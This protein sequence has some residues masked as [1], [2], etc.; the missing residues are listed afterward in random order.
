MD[1]P[2]SDGWTS[3]NGTDA[4]TGPVD[5]PWP[6]LALSAI[7]LVIVAVFSVRMQLELH[8][9]LVVAILRCF[10]QLSALGWILVP[11][12]KADSWWLTMLYGVLMVVVASFEAVSRPQHTFHG[13]LFFVVVILGTVAAVTVWFGLF[14]V[15]GVSPWYDP[16][17]MIPILGMVLGNSCSGISVG[18]TS[19]LNEFVTG[20]DHIELLLSFGASRMEATRECTHRAIQL[21]MTPLINAM[22]VVGVVAIPGMMTGQILGG[23]DPWVAAKYQVAIFQL[24][25]AAASVSSI[26]LVFLVGIVLFDGPSRLAD[27]P[28]KREG[29]RDW[30]RTMRT[31]REIRRR[32]DDSS[33]RDVREPLLGS[34]GSGGGGGGGG[35]GGGGGGGGSGG[36]GGGA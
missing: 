29:F 14:L 32:P 19:I 5:I 18:L 9:K 1:P 16:Q 8:H 7:P 4:G 26:L 6:H 11:I 22:N 15:V 17:Y 25:G 24:I 27:R 21:S 33:G 28:R 13:A 31:R 35:S 3:K 2:S 12:F 20:R 34:G 36:S 30:W 23:S 10:G